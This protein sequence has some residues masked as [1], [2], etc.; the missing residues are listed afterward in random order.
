MEKHGELLFSWE[1]NILIVKVSG[2][3]N[4]E[5]ALAGITAIKES[6][7]N[8]NKRIWHRLGF[9]DEEY[10]GSPSTMKMFKDAHIWCAEHGCQRVAVVVTNVVQQGVAEKIFSPHAKVFRGEADAREWLTS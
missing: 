6:V 1:E 3:F 7:C 10:L 5:G 8:K 9:W 2:S 4:K